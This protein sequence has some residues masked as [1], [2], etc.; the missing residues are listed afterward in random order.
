MRARSPRTAGRRKGGR[1]AAGMLAAFALLAPAVADETLV[2]YLFEQR[3]PSARVENVARAPLAGLYEV[4]ADGR[5]WYVDENVNYVFQG[6]LADARTQRNLTEERLR[7]LLAIPVSQL[8][9]ELAIPIVRGDGSRQLAVFTDPECGYCRQLEQELSAV[10]NVS[11]YVFLLPG[12]ASHPGSTLTAT[13][14]WCAG[15][16]AAAWNWR[17]LQG[18]DLNGREDC[19][20][21]F[22][23]IAA[24]ARRL[25]V[26]G[27][28]TLIFADG[29]RIAGVVT[30]VQVETAFDIVDLRS[31]QAREE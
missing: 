3:F 2:R 23:S 21:P 1:F 13:R 25:R 31:A 9:L 18:G 19:P 7:R 16:R 10:D 12:E 6:S 4:Y 17:V 26:T 28:P 24:L 8:P 5:I 30:A 14:I 11:I 29:R 15:D 22:E 20:T 27:T